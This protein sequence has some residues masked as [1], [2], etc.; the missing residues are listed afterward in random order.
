MISQMTTSTARSFAAIALAAVSWDGQLTMAGTRALRHCLDYRD[1][2]RSLDDTDIVA[3]LDQLLGDLRSMGA[4]HLMVEAAA[5]LNRD[6][7]QTAYAV[8]VEIMRSDGPLQSDERNI[9][10]NL[11]NVLELDADV[12]SSIRQVMDILHAP[13]GSAHGA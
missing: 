7:R 8:A 13:L 4:Q 1:P 5:Q 6:Q 12:V 2:F 10:E 11:S 9:L 3:L